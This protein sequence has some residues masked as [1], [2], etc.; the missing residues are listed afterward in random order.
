MTRFNSTFRGCS[1]T[2]V[3]ACVGN[4]GAPSYWEYAKG[5]SQAANL[6]IDQV[7]VNP[8]EYRLDEFIYPV[9]FNMR[10]SVELQLKGAIEQ[11]QILSEFRERKL[12]FN[13]SGSHD[14][15]LIWRFFDDQSRAID[16]RYA[17]INGE[18]RSRIL[19]IAEVDPTGQTFRYPVSADSQKHL[20]DVDVINFYN[21]KVQ[22]RVIS[23]NLTTLYNLNE[24][25]VKEYSKKTFTKNLSRHQIFSLAQNLPSRET[26]ISNDFKAVK[27]KVKHSFRLGSGELSAAIKMIEDHYEFSALIGLQKPLKGIA[28]NEVIQFL[29][30]WTKR[31]DVLFISPLFVTPEVMAGL[32]ALFYFA[33]DLDFSE[34]YI[35]TYE[36][37]LKR[38]QYA[39]SSSQDELECIFSSLLSKTNVMSN[40]VK[41]L[42]FLNQDNLVEN[43]VTLHGL[44]TRFSWL[45]D[46]RSRRLFKD[47]TAAGI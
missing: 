17:E 47:R 38:A 16:I 27:K 7:L 14:I 11:L 42:Y 26:W 37:E 39:L 43:L 44:D 33:Y 4:N 23:E 1:P 15:G 28:E 2:E 12:E 20:A 5:F 29:E 3:N 25:L 31:Y 32:N 41:T 19:D 13:L 40:F 24:Y 21:L 34:T 6:L 10:H 22:F 36:N 45:S 35:T 46:A 30:Q 9:C 8:I 18:L